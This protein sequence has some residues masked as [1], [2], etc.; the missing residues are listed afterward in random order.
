MDSSESTAVS[1]DMCVAA[2]CKQYTAILYQRIYL[3]GN[4][5]QILILALD[6]LIAKKWGISKIHTVSVLAPQE[7]SLSR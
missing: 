3:L 5:L 2:L 1:I 7:I 6:I 4:I